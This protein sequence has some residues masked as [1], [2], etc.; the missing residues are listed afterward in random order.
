MNRLQKSILLGMGLDAKDGHV[1]ITKGKNYRLFGGSEET[2]EEMQEH[3]VK[4]N[5]QLDKRHK[6]LDEVSPQEFLD[7]AEKAGLKI[8]RKKK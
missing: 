4:I 1:R 5:E 6:T 3:A 8:A 7:I 2:H